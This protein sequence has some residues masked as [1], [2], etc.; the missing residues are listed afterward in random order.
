MQ[1]Y[2]FEQAFTLKEKFKDLFIHKKKIKALEN[3]SE[4]SKFHHK[5][6][7]ALIKQCLADGFLDQ[8]ESDFLTHML[9]RYRINFLDWAHKT[10]WLKGEMSRLK[11]NYAKPQVQTAQQTFWDYKDLK[12]KLPSIN[13]PFEV[14][15]TSKFKPGIRGAK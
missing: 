1:T 3:F 12:Q 5:K 11:A 13:I 7:L 2:L 10:N 4:C 6:Y 15:A 9:D 14:L 8:E